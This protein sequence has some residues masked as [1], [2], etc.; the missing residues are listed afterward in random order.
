VYV[1]PLTAAVAVPFTAAKVDRSV[2]DP[3][4]RERERREVGARGGGDGEGRL[5]AVP[6]VTVAW[7]EVTV[8]VGVASHRAVTRQVPAEWSERS[9]TGRTT[10]R[11]P[12]H[13]D[14]K[15]TAPPQCRPWS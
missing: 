8:V 7:A 10:R 15:F 4:S 6:R 11:R 13:R 14:D 9:A 3:P 2:P 5:V 1:G 12:V